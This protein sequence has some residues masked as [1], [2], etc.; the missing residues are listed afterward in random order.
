VTRT[1]AAFDFD[2][3]LTRRDTLLP[4]LASVIGWPA[5][6]RRLG[7]EAPALARMSV[8]RADRDVTKERVLSRAL[9]GRPYAEVEQAGVAYGAVLAS[10]AIT[11]EMRDR[12]AWHQREGHE[13]VIVSASLDVYLCEV[14]RQ[15]DVEHT[16]CTSLERDDAGLCTGRM[17]GGNCRG[18]EKAKRLRAHL[19]DA[20]DDIELWA[21]GNSGGD[22]EM[23][24]MA[25]HP[26]R[27][28]RGRLKVS[29]Q[30]G[31]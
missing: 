9:A 3:T 28:R 14:A 2:G 22:D 17:L 5:L 30:L 24:A 16:L 21:Y 31:H 4:F 1:V 20:L 8:G 19:G 13:I 25:Q 10:D 27:V 23:L 15:L 6:A 12:V 7:A 11:Y 18:P 29:Q 26:V